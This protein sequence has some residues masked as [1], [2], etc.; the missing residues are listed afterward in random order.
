MLVETLLDVPFISVGSMKDRMLQ[1]T[2]IRID[3]RV[4][5]C[6]KQS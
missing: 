5:P 2:V 1:T 4:V 6:G 3:E